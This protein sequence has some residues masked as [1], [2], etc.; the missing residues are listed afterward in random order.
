MLKPQHNN[1]KNPKGK[2]GDIFI[3]NFIPKYVYLFLKGMK[4]WGIIFIM[5]LF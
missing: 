5:N 4:T 2:Y 3:D 1:K